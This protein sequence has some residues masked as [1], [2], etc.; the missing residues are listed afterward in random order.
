M[1]ILIV[2][3]T[4]GD[5]EKESGF[6][7]K[8]TKA[9]LTTGV[10]LEVVNGG[11][12]PALQDSISV[13][14]GIDVLVW[15]PNVDNAYPKLVNDIKRYYPNI[16]LV[17]SKFNNGKYTDVDLV[18][19]AL[20]SKANLLIEFTS[21][22]NIFSS[23]VID[24]LGNIFVETTNVDELVGIIYGR[25]TQLVSYTRMKSTPVSEITEVPNEGGFFEIVE[26]YGSKFHSLIHAVNQERYLGNCSFR[27]YNFRCSYGF[28]SFRGEGDIFVSK[29]NVDKR[30]ISK[31][32]F[33][34]VRL[35]LDGSCVEFQ[36]ANKPS[37]DTPIQL[38]LYQKFN[39]IN[40]MIHSHVF[41]EGAKFTEEMIPCGAL[42]EVEEIINAVEDI[43]ADYIEVNLKG[44]GSIVMAK[45]WQ[46][47]QNI[48][49]YK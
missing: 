6:V 15:M 23:K 45:H 38:Q 16:I 27:Q 11:S 36:G 12:F 1:K 9:F 24:P 3:G 13:L 18:A 29:R 7:N 26:S 49:Y 44:H 41:I 42:E 34:P 31:A 46:D 10:E 35:S 47:L 14:D 43:S 33:V 40:Y 37:V 39:N 22:G 48:K 19:R 21:K 25:T 5:I 4:F 30:N 20:K 32:S 17:Q 2:G 28:P 8:M